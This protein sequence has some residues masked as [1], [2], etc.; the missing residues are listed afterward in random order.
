MHNR[1][2]IVTGV[3][4]LAGIGR[5]ICLELA[6]DG[7]DIFFTYWSDYDKQMSWQVAPNEPDLIQEEIR[8]LGRKCEKLELDLS[9]PHA[10]LTLLNEVEATM[11]TADILINN[12]TYS[13]KTTIEDL[14]TEE[15][16]KH[17]NINIKATT[18]LTVEFIKRFKNTSLGR[19]INITSGQSLGQMPDELAYAVTKSAAETLTTTL[20]QKIA[21][22]GITINSVNPG[23]NDTGWMDEQLKKDL[24]ERFP[25]KRLGT[26]QDTANLICFLVSNKAEWVTGQIIHSEGGFIR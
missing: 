14:S 9:T 6:K 1:I 16:D 10:T 21:G 13:T 18:L 8:A 7:I 26:P 19:I 12:A 2:A 23:P 5:A 25:M 24:T 3:S 22:K 20:S 17:Y 15:L 4:R 11:G